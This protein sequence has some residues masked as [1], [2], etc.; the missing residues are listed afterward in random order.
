MSPSK[1]SL[2]KAEA[3][4]ETRDAHKK[5][6]TYL[7]IGAVI[8]VLAAGWLGW[9]LNDQFRTSQ[10]V[11]VRQ[12]FTGTVTT[13]KADGSAGCIQPDGKSA[14]VCSKFAVLVGMPV[15]QGDKVRAAFED[16]HIRHGGALGYNLLLIY[17]EA[18]NP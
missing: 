3:L 14:P 8:A 9:Y 15:H 1:A 10:Q 12:T 18:V 13:V 6:M 11:T 7:A 5:L 4:R 16:V 17:P 2:A